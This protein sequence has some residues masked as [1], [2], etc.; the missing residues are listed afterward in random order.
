MDLPTVKDAMVYLAMRGIY[1]N[2]GN[3]GQVMPHLYRPLVA[4]N[5]KETSATKRTLVAC[6]CG[7]QDQGRNA[8]EVIAEQVAQHWTAMG[9]DCKWGEYSFDSKS[10]M[11]VVKVYGVWEKTASE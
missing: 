5:M 2:N 8:C 3:P 9:G 10:A 1:V 7:P 6:V 11:H 4:V